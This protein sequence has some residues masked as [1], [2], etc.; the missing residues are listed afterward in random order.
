MN[1]SSELLLEKF[2]KRYITQKEIQAQANLYLLEN[3]YEHAYPYVKA[4]ALLNKESQTDK[5]TAGLVAVLLEKQEDAKELFS[6]VLEDDPA[7]YD[8]NYNLA[9]LEIKEE[10]YTEANNR[11]ESLLSTQKT[12]QF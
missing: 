2:E 3:N 9:L 8:A 1:V 12:Q 5:I 4:F 10:K 11:I 7:H 6:L